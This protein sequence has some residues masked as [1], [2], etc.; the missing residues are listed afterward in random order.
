MTPISLLRLMALLLG[1]TGAGGAWIMLI[2]QARTLPPVVRLESVTLRPDDKT[3]VILGRDALAQGSKGAAADRH[4]AVVHTDQGI[5]AHDIAPERKV[6]FYRASDG[7]YQATGRL[8]LPEGKSTLWIG[9]VAWTA[10]RSARAIALSHDKGPT[11]HLSIGGVTVIDG[12]TTAHVGPDLWE[13]GQAQLRGPATRLR[14]GGP[15]APDGLAAA[16]ERGILPDP[17]LPFGAAVLRLTSTGWQVESAER[18]VSIEQ[19]EGTRT[20]VEAR[21][22]LLVDASGQLQQR[23]MILG[24]TLYDIATPSGGVIRLTPVKRHVWVPEDEVSLTED[25]RI[26]SRLTAPRPRLSAG[27]LE[28]V[29]LITVGLAVGLMGLAV[30]PGPGRAPALA[31][32]GMVM[33][34]STLP[35]FVTVVAAIGAGMVTLATV[36]AF[37]APRLRPIRTLTLGG[38][39]VVS[40]GALT[41]GL[42]ESGAP[43]AIGFEYKL[44][45]AWLGLLAPLAASRIDAM[46]TAFWSGLVTLATFGIV[47]AARLIALEPTE[48]WVA[49]FEKHLFALAAIGLAAAL[50]LDIG[51]PDLWPAPVLR[52]RLLPRPRNRVALAVTGS[53]GLAFAAITLLGDETGFYGHF[54]PS[55]VAKSLLVLLVAVTVCLDLARRQM[56]TAQEGALSLVPPLVA[57]AIAGA[58]G[59]ASAAN[60][61][62]S[63]ILVCILAILAALAAG[64]SLHMTQWLNRARQRSHDGLPIPRKSGAQPPLQWRHSR[65]IRARWSSFWPLAILGLLLCLPLVVWLWLALSQSFAPGTAFTGPSYLLTPWTR[66]QS[67]ADMTLALQADPL[68]RFPE[69]G[70][71]LKLG[72]LALLEAPCRT[73]LP[74]LCPANAPLADP[75][76]AALLKVP[77][78]QDDFASVSLVQALGPDGA[79][80]YAAGQVALVVLALGIGITALLAP[81][82][83]R[84]GAWLLGCATI[85][86]AALFAAQVTVPWANALGLLPIMGQPMT[87]VSLGAS[88]HLGVALPFAVVTLLTCYATRAQRTTALDIHHQL[89]RRRFLI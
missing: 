66:V 9:D 43:A 67:H 24:H 13:R 45:G 84:T 18:P 47:A 8:P 52:R 65:R 76:P 81:S 85:G 39:G 28:R 41:L 68:I 60:Y 42:Q 61:D 11:I 80:L 86:L 88:H 36:S 57:I 4:L 6:G 16:L 3:P 40:L 26:T 22:I 25:P 33:T 1:L 75:D 73:G 79:L 50:A 29:S 74:Q 56:L 72:R 12:D 21:P 69:A 2:T 38:L 20:D 48:A 87:F 59:G 5:V 51:R 34:L 30:G 10:N 17:R 78:I 54:Q 62:M 19:P 32:A 83:F 53:V 64:T 58:I 55:E 15:M 31:T 23:R 7:A 49:L 77:A 46:G 63:P 37:L 82:E 14:L 89:Q 71:Q 70:T 44:A 35:G 27:L